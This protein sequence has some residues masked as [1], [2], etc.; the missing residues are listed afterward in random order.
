MNSIC[1]IDRDGVINEMVDRG[2]IRGGDGRLLRYSAPWRYSE[3]RLQPGVREALIKLGR[4][5]FLRIVVTN[6]PDLAYGR[7]LSEDH[8]LMM[9][10]LARLPLEDIYIC[11][12]PSSEG[13][14]CHKPK[15]GMLLAAARKWHGD[16]SRSFIIGDTRSDIGAGR[17]AGCKTILVRAPYNQGLEADFYADDLFGAALLIR[18]LLEGG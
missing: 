11:P 12:H 13:C 18:Q 3:F 2:E 7:L 4:L 5:G 8:A 16:L 17:A 6:Q 9:S 14:Y 15:P 10:G 1:F